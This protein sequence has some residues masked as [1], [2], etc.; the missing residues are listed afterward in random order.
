MPGGR[1]EGGA[2]E[3]ALREAAEA[4]YLEVFRA[5]DWK[6]VL[7]PWFVPSDGAAKAV[8]GV[9]DAPPQMGDPGWYARR[10]PAFEVEKVDLHVGGAGRVFEEDAARRRENRP[11]VLR[12]EHADPREVRGIVED[13]G[14]LAVVRVEV[15]GD[16]VL[17]EDE[18]VLEALDGDVA[19]NLLVV[20]V[21]GGVESDRVTGAF[22][23]SEGF[24]R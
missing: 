17:A 13:D 22:E 8:A 5:E 9:E 16:D 7:A 14:L 2:C 24:A 1:L 12:H 20:L 3:G 4:P 19:E 18:A 21:A 6:G 23:E 11:V 15:V 10:L